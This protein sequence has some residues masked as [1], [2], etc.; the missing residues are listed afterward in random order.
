MLQF[1]QQQALLKMQEQERERQVWLEQQKQQQ[2]MRQI[3]YT[4]YGMGGKSYLICLPFHLVLLIHPLFFSFCRY[5]FFLCY[6]CKFYLFFLLPLLLLL[7]HTFVMYSL[8]S[9]DCLYFSPALL[10]LH[11]VLVYICTLSLFSFPI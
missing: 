10:I 9:P 3:Q 8:F 4:A 7:S 11:P 6:F 1:Q 2:Q 5:N